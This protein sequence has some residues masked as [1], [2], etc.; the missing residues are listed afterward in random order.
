MQWFRAA[1]YSTWKCRGGSPILNDQVPDA[2][3]RSL[4]VRWLVPPATA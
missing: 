1:Q 3:I 2:D 4:V